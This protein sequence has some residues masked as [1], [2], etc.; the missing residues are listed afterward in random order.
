MAGRLLIAALL[1]GV[2]L[3]GQAS[4]PPATVKPFPPGLSGTL[5]FQS[6]IPG[7][8]IPD[9]RIHIFTLDLATG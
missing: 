9:G 1:Y 6:D 7:P 2:T 5:V 3:H 8:D 4:A